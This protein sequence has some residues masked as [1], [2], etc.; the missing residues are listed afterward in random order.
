MELFSIGF[1]ALEVV[2]FTEI[3]LDGVKQPEND[4][5]ST[6]IASVDWNVV[7]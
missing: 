5:S 7:E 4:K 6:T 3:S 1:Q 2:Q